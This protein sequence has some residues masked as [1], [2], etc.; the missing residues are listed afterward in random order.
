MDR[1][2]S[3]R[4][5]LIG[6]AASAVSLLAGEGTGLAMAQAYVLAG[7]LNRA[8]TDYRRAFARQERLLR[9]FIEGKQA[10][11]RRFAAVF[12]PTTPVG[13]WAR[14]QA[15]KLLAMPWLGQRIWRREIS[16]AL[17]LPQYGM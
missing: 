3:G 14:N 11:A 1:W 4:V 6:D 15:T 13:V 2:S 12:A 16:D 9:G 17:V 7:E 10:S 8:D 5:A